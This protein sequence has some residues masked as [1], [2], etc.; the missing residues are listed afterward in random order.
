MEKKSI[1]ILSLGAGVQSSTLALLYAKGLLT[2]MPVAAVFADTQSEP[3][4]VYDYLDYIASLVPFPVIR[5]T[6]GNLAQN[7]LDTLNGKSKRCGQPPFYVKQPNSDGRGGMLWRQC[8][9]DY[10]LAPIARAV[11]KLAKEHGAK[12]VFQIVGIS[13]DEMTRMKAIGKKYVANIFPLIDWKWTRQ[14]CLKWMKE[15]GYREPAKSACW[16]CPYAN[17]RRWQEMKEKDPV[18]FAKACEFDESMRR[19]QAANKG[20]AGITGQLFV[21]RSFKPLR[22]AVFTDKERGIIELSFQDECDGIC[23]T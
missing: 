9:K 21:H 2:P 15:N 8:T 16:M 17:N 14:A 1:H 13:Y 3:Q 4:A 6:T 12:H 19:H 11:R 10:K 5:C 7:F 18:S 23:N 22:E 20:A